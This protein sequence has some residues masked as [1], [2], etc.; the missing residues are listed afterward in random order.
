MYV[1]MWYRL[2]P[3]ERRVNS[4]ESVSTSKG[5]CMHRQQASQP[6]YVQL[7]SMSASR[8]ACACTLRP[9]RGRRP[10]RSSRTRSHLFGPGR[11]VFGPN[12][13]EEGSLAYVRPKSTSS[14][15]ARPTG[16]YSCNLWITSY[17]IE[18]CYKKDG[19]LRKKSIDAYL[20]NATFE[21]I[22]RLY[23]STFY[24]Q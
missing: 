5:C 4:I 11:P 19:I 22:S 10:L 18:I 12:K 14:A 8:P 15:Q 24:Q 3:D 2:H 13:T 23:I 16:S 7:L 17:I 6:A 9:S 21:L 1:R 20:G